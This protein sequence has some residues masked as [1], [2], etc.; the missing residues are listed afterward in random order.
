MKSIEPISDE[1]LNAFLDGQMDEGER[2]RII[3][4]ARNDKALAEK[5]C[6]LRHGKDMIR[7]AYRHTP[8]HPGVHPRGIPA[9]S[10]RSLGAAAII[11]LLGAVCGWSAHDWWPAQPAVFYSTAQAPTSL[12]SDHILLHIDSM[13]SAR[14]R[15]AFNVLENLLAN[16][17]THG[18]HLKLEVVANS[19][20][21]K[22]L[23][24]NSPYAPRIAALSKRHSNLSFLACG[25]AME[26][27]KLKEGHKVKLLPQA[28]RIDA[29]LGRI[30]RRLREG[31]T[32]VKG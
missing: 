2:A 32:Y 9:A 7:L 22:L 14:I 10:W 19:S 11:L 12:A 25:V 3:Q 30:V 20:G 26:N 28:H 4:A 6:S 21:L 15:K 18:R 5:L 1:Q 8:P 23:R 16:D 24:A 29:A 17:Q 13:D 31:W 27:A